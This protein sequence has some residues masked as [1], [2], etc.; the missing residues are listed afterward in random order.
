MSCSRLRKRSSRKPDS[1]TGKFITTYPKNPLFWYK[2]IAM[3]IQVRKLALIEE[4]LKI[5]DENLINKL[6]KLFQTETNKLHDRELKPMSLNEFHEMI[7]QAK[8]D[9]ENSRVISHND[10]KAKVNSWK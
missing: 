4:I 9:K 10:L 1:R 7:D 8:L 3:N 5:S 2:K 6:Q